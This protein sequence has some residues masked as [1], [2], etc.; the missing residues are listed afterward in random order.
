MKDE[1]VIA[2]VTKLHTLQPNGYTSDE[3]VRRQRDECW[4]FFK[5]KHAI[6]IGIS[7]NQQVTKACFHYVLGS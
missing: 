7:P 3:P 5:K 4:G 2:R 1:Q 6:H